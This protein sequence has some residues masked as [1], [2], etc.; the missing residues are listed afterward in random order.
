MLFRSG[1]LRMKASEKTI[2]Q[3]GTLTFIGRRQTEP[4]FQATTAIDVSSLKEGGEAGITAYA[5]HTNHYDVVVECR[6]GRKY[7]KAYI[8]IGQVRHVEKE[9]PLNTDLIY[10]RIEGDY[11]YYHLSYSED[12]HR[13]LPLGKM[14]YRYL[15]T[16]TIGGF[17]GVHLGLFAQQAKGKSGGSV[18]VDWFRY[19]VVK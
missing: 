12:N 7:V 2:D 15:S 17:T 4:R 11:N 19:S 10:L 13:F 6:G 14:E 1:Y 16:E 3:V 9:F 8:R 5:A 18:D